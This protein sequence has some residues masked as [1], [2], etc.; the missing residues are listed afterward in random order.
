MQSDDA[1]VPAQSHAMAKNSA[2]G[3]TNLESS[4]KLP[5]SITAFSVSC[6]TNL[7]GIGSS[8]ALHVNH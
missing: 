7:Y 6:R 1:V 3:A 4:G 2:G 5:M 8:H